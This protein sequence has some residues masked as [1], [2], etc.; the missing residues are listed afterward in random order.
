MGVGG[1][2]LTPTALPS[3]RRTNTQ[4]TEIWEGPKG[5]PEESVWKVSPSPEFQRRTI[6]S[7]TTHYT[8]YIIWLVSYK[9]LHYLDGRNNIFSNKKG[10]E[11]KALPKDRTSKTS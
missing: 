3:G 6:Q 8:D 5:S 2:H 1:Q 11:Y 9:I 7:V 4:Y 10:V